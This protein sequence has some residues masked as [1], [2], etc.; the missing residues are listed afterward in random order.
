LGDA[1]T[2]VMASIDVHMQ[3]GFCTSDHLTPER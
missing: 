1:F 2:L 3:C